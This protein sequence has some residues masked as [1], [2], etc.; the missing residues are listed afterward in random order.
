M[1]N[2]LEITGMVIIALGAILLV[3]AA[4][5]VHVLPDTLSRQHAATMAGSVALTLICLGVAFIQADGQWTWKLGIVV[6]FLFLTLPLGSHMVAR[7]ATVQ[8]KQDTTKVGK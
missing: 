3:L 5:G 1:N 6:V 8:L 7:A 4:L 2:L